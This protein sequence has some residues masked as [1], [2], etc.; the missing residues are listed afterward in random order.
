EGTRRQLEFMSYLWS[1]AA[2]PWL[3]GALALV[4]AALIVAIYLR[5]G[6]TADS[7]YKALLAGL[8]LF[9]V[10][11]MLAVLLPQLQL[12][13]RREGWPDVAILIDDS[14][15]MSVT[16]HYQDPAVAEVAQRL[17]QDCG[18]SNPE[19]LQIAQA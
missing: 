8:R 17:G 7:S 15:S 11:L 13:I 1:A 3:A 12:S 9:L 2:D 10:L 19:R 6:R 14:R 5:E 18:L 4:L 16:D